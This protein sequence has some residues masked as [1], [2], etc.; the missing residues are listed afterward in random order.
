MVN[1]KS[2]LPAPLSLMGMDS[3]PLLDSAGALTTEMTAGFDFDGGVTLP[4]R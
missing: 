1:Q 2:T 4:R 3:V